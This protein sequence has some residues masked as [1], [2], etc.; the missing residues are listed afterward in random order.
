MSVRSCR[1]RRASWSMT[2]SLAAL[3]RLSPNVFELTSIQFML[4]PRSR[5]ARGAT[6]PPRDSPRRVAGIDGEH[7][8]G[9]VRGLIRAQP[10]AR[11][12]DLLRLPEAAEQADDRRELLLGHADSLERAAD[13]RRVDRA[14]TD[15]VDADA[16]RG[17][18]ERGHLGEA[19]HAVLGRDVRRVVRLRPERADRADVDDRPAVALLE[20][21]RELVLEAQGDALEIDR[22]DAVELLLVELGEGVRVRGDRGVVDRAVE[23][24]VALDRGE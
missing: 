24:P 20:H 1:A 14:G 15:R 13:H 22:Q 5:Q 12:R 4:G 23:P 6:G 2:V 21:L 3:M 10:Q 17:V 16:L 19:D 8:A 9:H 7:G 11:L 18:L